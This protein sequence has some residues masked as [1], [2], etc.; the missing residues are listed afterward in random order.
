MMQAGD[1]AATA[2]SFSF[3]PLGLKV[4]HGAALPKG[5]PTKALTFTDWLLL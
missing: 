1:G 4:E 2:G 5:S 3:K